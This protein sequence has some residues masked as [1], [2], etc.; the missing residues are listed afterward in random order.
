ME[1]H[2]LLSPRIFAVAAIVLI[3][4]LIGL[5]LPAYV[6]AMDDSVARAMAL[7][8]ARETARARVRRE[9]AVRR[10]VD[11]AAAQVRLPVEAGAFSSRRQARGSLRPSRQLGHH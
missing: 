4:M 6:G 8:A 7:P 9:M 11:S 5:A 1:K 2:L 10:D 3:A